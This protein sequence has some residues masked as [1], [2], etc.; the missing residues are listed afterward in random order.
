MDGASSPS[1]TCA[2]AELK[3]LRFFRWL[4]SANCRIAADGRCVVGS[5][6]QVPANLALE[7]FSQIYKR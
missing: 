3:L 5:H 2:G 7:S 1:P 6:G 4:C